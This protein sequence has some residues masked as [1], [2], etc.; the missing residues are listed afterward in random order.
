MEAW[1]QRRLDDVE[2]VYLWVDGMYVK[3]GLEDLSNVNYSSPLTTI[4]FPS[5]VTV[6]SFSL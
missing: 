3:V 6:L 4:I 5:W 2:V 1:K